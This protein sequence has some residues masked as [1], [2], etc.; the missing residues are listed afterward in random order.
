MEIFID[1]AN[2]FEIEEALKRGFV[3]GITTNPTLLSKEPKAGFIQHIGNI[4]EIIRFY[5][6]GQDD[7]HLSVEVFSRD[8]QE[9]VQQAMDFK[10]TFGY[11]NLSVKVPI[12]WD[13]LEAIKKL[14]KEGFSVNC[15]ACM[16]VTQAVMAAAAGAR[17]VSLFWGRIRDG[18]KELNKL[19][20][21][22]AQSTDGAF[23]QN[24]FDPAKVVS[25]TRSILDQS[26]AETEIIVGSI[27]QVIDV[28]D[29]ALAGAHI[30][31]IPP[32]F[33]KPM[34]SHFKTDEVVNQFL[35]D[36]QSWL[37]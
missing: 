16:S 2:L 29:A 14:A 24:D 17:F 9:I 7:I 37:K 8:T 30:I 25:A 18:G 19:A 6:D 10:K 15:T 5:R 32:K 33:F 35:T 34:V 31:T 23:D 21:L 1:T 36:F 12:G 20:M 3:R 22:V 4:I 28:R 13:E 27:R 26:Y 11:G